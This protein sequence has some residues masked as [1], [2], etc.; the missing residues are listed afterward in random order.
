MELTNLQKEKVAHLID[1][2]MKGNISA[3][4]QIY[5]LLMLELWSKEFQVV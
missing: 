4:Y 5:D 3:E 2:F 1:E